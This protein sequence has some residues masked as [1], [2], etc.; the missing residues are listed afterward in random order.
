MNE[1][2]CKNLNGHNFA[3]FV[4]FTCFNFSLV[5]LD[6][7]YHFLPVGGAYTPGNHLNTATAASFRHPWTYFDSRI[8]NH[9]ISSLPFII[10]HRTIIFI[11][12]LE[13]TC[14]PPCPGIP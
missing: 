9:V 5:C 3:K 4:R 14:F 13:R 11:F 6:P 7:L 1:K 2:S 12:T 8:F 10:I